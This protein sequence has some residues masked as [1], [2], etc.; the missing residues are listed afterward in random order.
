MQE[1][2]TK[3]IPPPEGVGIKWED[4]LFGIFSSWD[5]RK[6]IKSFKKIDVKKIETIRYILKKFNDLIIFLNNNSKTIYM[7]ILL[8]YEY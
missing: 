7:L 8:V 2:K 6:G 1:V 5:L 4:R 3:E